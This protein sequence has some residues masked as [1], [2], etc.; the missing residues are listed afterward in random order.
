[1]TKKIAKII[2]ISTVPPVTV[3]GLLMLFYFG[4]NDVFANVWHLIITMIFLMVMPFLAYPLSYIIPKIKS[5]GRDGQRNLAFALSLFGY[6]LGLVYAFVFH[7]SSNLF[8]VFLTYFL[9]VLI[10]TVL[11]RGFKIK[12][13]GHACSI[14]G[15]LV[16]VIYFFGI[17]SSIWCVIVFALV[18]WSSLTLK[19]HTLNELFFGSLSS[20]IAFFISI[21]VVLTSGI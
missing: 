9:S 20:V 11:N 2:R 6:G 3:F 18:V 13:S 14:A 5:K 7:I 21:A 16:S 15:P 4:L 17:W 19:R 1:M 8:V 12:A 10:L